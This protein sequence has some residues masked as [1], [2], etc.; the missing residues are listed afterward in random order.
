MKEFFKNNDTNNAAAP[1]LKEVSDILETLELCDTMMPSNPNH[2]KNNVEQSKKDLFY[3]MAD[4]TFEFVE[5]KLSLFELDLKEIKKSVYQDE[6]QTFFQLSDIVAI[7]LCKVLGFELGRISHYVRNGNR[8]NDNELTLHK[9]SVLK[10]K[11]FFNRI[12]HLEKTKISEIELK[13]FQSQVLYLDNKL[14]NRSF[15]KRFVSIFR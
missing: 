2:E 12:I 1:L 13:K 8:S 4:N 3:E 7:C 11:G 5:L 15:I 14:N 6:M 10:I 9:G